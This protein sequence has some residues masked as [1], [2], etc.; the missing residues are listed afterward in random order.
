[1]IRRPPRS[2]LFPYTTLFRSEDEQFLVTGERTVHGNRLRHITDGAANA[3]WLGGEG[4]TGHARLARRGRQE[5]G[6]HLDRGGLARPVGAE[7]TENLTG[8]DR[9][10][11]RIHCRERAEAAGQVF[12]FENNVA[13]GIRIMK[14]WRELLC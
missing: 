4:E 7:Q 2:T 9:K 11:Q 3:D 5:R 12:N 6:E 10:S 14:E 8:V 13:H 1:M